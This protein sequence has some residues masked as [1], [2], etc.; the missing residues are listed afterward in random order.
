[1]KNYH[2]YITSVL[3][4]ISKNQ[5]Y[6]SAELLA[7]PLCPGLNGAVLFYRHPTES[8]TFVVSSI[9]GLPDGDRTKKYEMMI[10][11]SVPHQTSKPIRSFNR[12]CDSI[13]LPNVSGNS[14]FAF[15]V[16]YTEELSTCSI[17]GR[18]I[19]IFEGGSY[20]HHPSEALACGLILPN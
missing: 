4:S 11:G 18:T 9:F 15:S 16:F 17:L 14:G 6:A 19:S 12:A 8:G 2:S 13:P 10:R 7:T 1:M 3:G 20:C 5:I